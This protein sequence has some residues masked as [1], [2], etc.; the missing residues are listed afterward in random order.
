MDWKDLNGTGDEERERAALVLFVLA[1]GKCE[2]GDRI[3]GPILPAS[4]ILDCEAAA[5]LTVQK[6]GE[7][8]AFSHTWSVHE[9]RRGKGKLVLRLLLF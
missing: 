5:D 7:G 6:N 1:T 3:T 4:E 9:Q 8:V 2:R